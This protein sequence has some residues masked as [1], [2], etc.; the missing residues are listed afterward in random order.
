VLFIASCGGHW[1]RRPLLNTTSICFRRSSTLGRPENRVKIRIDKAVQ[2]EDR[3]MW[4]YDTRETHEI[5]P[6]V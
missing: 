2:L 3:L 1:R 6:R 5:G 4:M